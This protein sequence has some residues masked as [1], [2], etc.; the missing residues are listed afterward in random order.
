M[1]TI[2]LIIYNE[3]SGGELIK[4]IYI[5]TFLFT[6]VNG[7]VQNYIYLEKN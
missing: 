2:V 7:R 1:I 5:Y 4:D 3:E 6:E